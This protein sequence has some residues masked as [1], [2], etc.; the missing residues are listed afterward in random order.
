MRDYRRP[1]VRV[2]S[3]VLGFYLPACAALADDWPQWLGPQRDGVWR[4]SGILDKFPKGG[5]KQLW[6][7]PIGGG[8]AG[9][10]VV[11]DRVFVTDR[12]L[13]PGNKPPDVKAGG[14]PRKGIGEGTERILRLSAKD[15]KPPR[16]PEYDCT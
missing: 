13:A 11:G 5:P 2:L 7:V 14:D 8:Y 12:Q 6:K 3:L 15:G 9:P 16:K 4:E 10:A 1:G